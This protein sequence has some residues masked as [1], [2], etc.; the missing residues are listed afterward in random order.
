MPNLDRAERETF[1]EKILNSLRGFTL[2]LI[3]STNVPY[4]R[5]YCLLKRNGTVNVIT[6]GD[7]CLKA[8]LMDTLFA[9][10]K[11]R[12]QAHTA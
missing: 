1:P 9:R 7:R 5:R 4:T 10:G 2:E 3:Y 12:A 8:I 11:P 6:L